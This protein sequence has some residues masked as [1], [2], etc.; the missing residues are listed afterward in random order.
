MDANKLP[1]CLRKYSH[2]IESVSD[3]RHGP[4]DDGYWVYLMPGWLSNEVHCIHE[5]NPTQCAKVFSHGLER[6]KNKSCCPA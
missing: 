1:K 2:L 3:E 6:C 4:N 5:E